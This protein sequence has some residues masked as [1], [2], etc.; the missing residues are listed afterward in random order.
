[1]AS[2]AGDIDGL[3]PSLTRY[4]EMFLSVAFYLLL[5]PF[6]F[7]PFGV[8]FNSPLLGVSLYFFSDWREHRKLTT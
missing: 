8:L 3:N 7:L 4:Q 6:G 5:F 2:Y 1:M